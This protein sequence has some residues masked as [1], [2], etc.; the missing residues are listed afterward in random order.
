MNDQQI[1]KQV[2][3]KGLTA[4]RVT[5][6]QIEDAIKSEHYFTAADG[7]Y[8][9]GRERDYSEKEWEGIKGPLQ[10]VTVCVMILKNGHRIVGVNEGPVSPANFDAELGRSMARQKAVDQIWPLEGY[11]LKQKLSETPKGC[12][13]AK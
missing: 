3:A 7:A 13:C 8:Q 2:V 9:A 10:L 6:Q 1:E 5:P 12:P 4:P 11:L